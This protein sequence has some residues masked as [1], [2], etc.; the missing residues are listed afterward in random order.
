MNDEQIKQ[1]KA[2]FIEAANHLEWCG[3]GDSYERECA[4][5]DKLPQRIEEMVKLLQQEDARH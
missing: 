2:L 3:Y 1:L 5:D 4:R